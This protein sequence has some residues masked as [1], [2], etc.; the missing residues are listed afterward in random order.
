[1]REID[2]KKSH[3]RGNN[4]DSCQGRATITIESTMEPR[5]RGL[6]PV[7]RGPETILKQV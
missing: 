7:E 1:M 2:D 4:E 5:L 6:S 3:N